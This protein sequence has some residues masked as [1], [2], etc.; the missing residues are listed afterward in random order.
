M[1][2]FDQYKELAGNYLNLLSVLPYPTAVFRAV[3]GCLLA[4][5]RHLLNYLKL[6][7]EEIAEIA[8]TGFSDFTKGLHGEGAFS[9]RLRMRTID[10]GVIL[11]ESPGGF[12]SQINA[13]VQPVRYGGQDCWLVTAAAESGQNLSQKKNSKEEE[14]YRALVENLNDIVYTTDKNAVITYVSPNIFQ[15]SGYEPCEVI[16]KCFTEFV[17][18]EDLQGR[19]EQFLKILSGANQATEYRFITKTGE[20]KWARTSARPIVHDEQVA[21][22]QGI[23]VDISDRKKIEEA[24]RSSEEKYRI[25][26]QNSKDAIF[27]I[28]GDYIKFMNPSASEILGHPCE[29]IADRSFWEFVHPEDRAALMD[30]YLRRMRGERLSDRVAFRILNKGGDVRDVDLNA[31]LITW[32][33]EP[34]VLNFLRDVTVQ[35]RMEDQLRN[36]QKMEALGTLSGGIAHNF[37]NL[38]MGIHGNASLSL[39]NLSPSELAFKYLEKIINLVQSGSKLTRQLLEYARGVQ[40]EMGTMDLNQL[41]IDASETLAATKKHIQIRYKL[42]K[43][44]PCIKADQG[45]IE[46]VLLNLLLNSADAMAAAGEVVIETSCVKGCQAKGKAT[47]SKN[48]DYVLVRVSDHGTG[49][50]QNIMDRIFEPFFTTKGLGHGTGLGLSTAYGIVKNHDGDIC[51]ESE[52]NKGSSF[53]IYLPALSAESMGPAANPESEKVAGQG[54]ILLVDD[55]PA[56]IDPSATLLEHL[57]F[58]VLKAPSASLAMKIFQKNWKSIDL[59][60]LDLILHKTSGRELYYKFRELNPQVKVLLSSGFSLSGQAEELIANGCRGFIQKP[61]AIT[62]LSKTMMDILSAE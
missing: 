32:E 44:I 52:V 11:F 3:D 9:D 30:R 2:S 53:F 42:S 5:N 60:I 62:K 57:G 41:I 6:P 50:P 16:G 23:L 25:L 55:E 12:R 27:V 15:L 48:M 17:H 22:V 18:P 47:L 40:C 7:G 61:Y 29:A 8:G 26:V 14:S 51:V 31:V 43:E 49:I 21:G 59:V 56:V 39:I 4:A 1:H 45:Q 34:A 24:L 36:S 46:Q 37:N 58:T 10:D 38:L 54:T 13:D 19:M 35:K 33:G 20:L 28:Q